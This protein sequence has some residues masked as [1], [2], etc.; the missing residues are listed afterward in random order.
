MQDGNGWADAGRDG[1]QHGPDG[2]PRAGG[3]EPTRRLDDPEAT[4]VLGGGR[5]LGGRYR[6]EGLLGAGRSSEVHRATD[7]RLNRPVAVKLFPA[8]ADPN[9]ARRFTDEAQTLANLSHPGLVSVYDS[10]LEGDRPYLVME[11]I[12]GSTLREVIAQEQLPLEEVTRIG[13]ELADALGYVHQQGLVHRDVKPSN[14]LI[15]RDNRVRLADCGIGPPAARDRPA[16]SAPAHLSPEQVRGEWVGPPAD[17]YGLGLVLLEV[18][19]G[20]VEYPGA[21]RQAAEARLNRSPE[22]PAELPDNFRRALL[23]MTEPDPRGRPTASQAASMLTA[24]PAPVMLAASEPPARNTTTRIL[25]IALGALLLAGL[26]GLVAL[27]TGDDATSTKPTSGAQSSGSSSSATKSPSTTRRTPTTE[28]TTAATTGSTSTKTT[29]KLPT[30]G[31]ALPSVPDINL[32]DTSGL[33]GSVT[34][35]IKKAWQKLTDW[36]SKLF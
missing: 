14:V 24:E 23:A 19:T 21:G 25:V 15:G 9:S 10:G 1:D 22:V 13:T 3:P 35:E 28:P 18:V 7:V 11:L 20:R 12:S 32:P 2:M 8:G 6:L 29:P 5:M 30:S 31:I 27:A 4:Q 16:F 33:S 26:I 36:L 34:D 17:V